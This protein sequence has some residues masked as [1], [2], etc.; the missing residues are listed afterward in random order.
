LDLKYKVES[1]AF[2]VKS[3][4]AALHE[5]AKEIEMLRHMFSEQ[6]KMRFRLKIK[7]MYAFIYVYFRV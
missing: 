4:E 2:V 1:H 7:G 6:Q 3:H 5:Q